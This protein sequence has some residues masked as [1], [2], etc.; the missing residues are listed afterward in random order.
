M[1]NKQKKNINKKKCIEE[2]NRVVIFLIILV[3]AI[4]LFREY[5][6]ITCYPEIIT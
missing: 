2:Q 6:G 1:T 4:F 3:C 5:I